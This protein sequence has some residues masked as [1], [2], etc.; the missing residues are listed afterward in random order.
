MSNIY[1]IKE[2]PNIYTANLRKKGAPVDYK[3]APMIVPSNMLYQQAP[4]VLY[5]QPPQVVYQQAPQVLYQ[6]APQVLHSQAQQGNV[7][8]GVG[9]GRV[10]G[11]QIHQGFAQQPSDPSY[12]ID[13]NGR[14]IPVIGSN[15][16][17]PRNFSVYF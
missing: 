9:P 10:I 13:Q 8:V 1:E 17:T 16:G 12:I 11:Y 6:Q 5:Q 15:N 7:M 4:Q 3:T 14:M 2:M